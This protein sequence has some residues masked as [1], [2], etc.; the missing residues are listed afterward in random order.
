VAAVGAAAGG[1]GYVA[2][3]LRPSRRERMWRGLRR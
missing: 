3:R 2:A 1:G